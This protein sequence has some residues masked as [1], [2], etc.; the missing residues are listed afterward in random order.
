MT[1]LYLVSNCQALA[2]VLP[3]SSEYCGLWWFG[4]RDDT[5]MVLLRYYSQK[6]G[7]IK[8]MSKMEV[9]ATYL[10]QIVFENYT[11]W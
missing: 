3:S 5:F 8:I 2:G 9:I 7:E 11:Q 1:S 6:L 10:L 4:S